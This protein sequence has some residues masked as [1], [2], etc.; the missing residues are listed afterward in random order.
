MDKRRRADKSRRAAVVRE[1]SKRYDRVHGLLNDMTTELV[2]SIFDGGCIYCGDQDGPLTLDR[3]DNR[4]GHVMTNVVAACCRCNDVRGGM[5]H[6]AWLIVAPAMRTARERGL[7][8]SWF[9]RHKM[10]CLAAP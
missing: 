7:F 6:E 1:D 4:L 8:G 3:I 2:V 10:T 9:G 5:P